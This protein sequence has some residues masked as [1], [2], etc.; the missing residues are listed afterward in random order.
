MR[1]YILTIF[2]FFTTLFFAPGILHAQ[3][4]QGSFQGGSWLDA[5]VQ[6]QQ[7]STPIYGSSVFQQNG[8]VNNLNTSMNGADF[9]QTQSLIQTQSFINT[10]TNLNSPDL[11]NQNAFSTGATNG[12]ANPNQ[13]NGQTSNTISSFVPDNSGTC[14]TTFVTVLDILL[15]F[16]CIISVSIIPLLF[17]I[18]IS[19]FVWGIVQYIKNAADSKKREEGRNFMIYGVVSIFVIVSMWGLVGF[20]RNTFSLGNGQVLLPRTPRQNVII[21]P[22]VPTSSPQ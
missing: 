3:Q 9:Q 14:S 10:P 15:F 1:S 12:T 21:T 19:V 7:T 20:L 5:Y 16:K 22:I 13:F 11:V 18:A 17:A 6:I 8:S 2:I 4:I